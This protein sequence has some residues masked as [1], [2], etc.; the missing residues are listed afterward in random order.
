[1]TKGLLFAALLSAVVVPAGAAA[2]R[3]QLGERDTVVVDPQRAY[4]LYRTPT[5][6]DVR[7]LREV[8]EA[9]G[10]AHAERRQRAFARARHRYEQ[11]ISAWQRQ[12]DDCG[13]RDAYCHAALGPRPIE[14]TDETF[15][16]PPPELDNFVDVSRGRVFERSEG[17]FTYLRAIEPGNYVVY[18]PMIV[19]PN[20]AA[21]GVCLCMGSVR[22]E[23]RPGQI[24]DLGELR[25]VPDEA[26]AGTAQGRFGPDGRLPSPVLVA[27]ARAD[28]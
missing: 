3:D 4:I 28:R 1:M 11:D 8:S 13:R 6:M 14:V 20:G 5:R 12:Y 2:A 19:A 17:S 7:F 9:Q 10:A 22:F 18:G 21:A 15:A 16:Y 24:V 23:A 25:L 27:P 26:D